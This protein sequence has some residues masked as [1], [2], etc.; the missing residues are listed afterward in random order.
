M[1]VSLPQVVSD[2]AIKHM[3]ELTQLQAAGLDAI[4][5]LRCAV[6]FVVNRSDCKAFRPCHE[7]D[8]LFADVV[9]RAEMQGGSCLPC[10]HMHMGWGILFGTKENGQTPG[11]DKYTV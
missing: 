5:P 11:T 2:R 4:G 8:M 7:A 10:I 3:H 1:C 6:L 9:K